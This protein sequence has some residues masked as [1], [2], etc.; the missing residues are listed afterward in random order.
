[1]CTWKIDLEMILLEGALLSHFYVG[2]MVQ[3][4]ME[5]KRLVFPGHLFTGNQSVPMSRCTAYQG[6]MPS[7][8][9]GLP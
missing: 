4:W 2:R 7:S 3:V 1:M 6:R 8:E 9:G 5:K